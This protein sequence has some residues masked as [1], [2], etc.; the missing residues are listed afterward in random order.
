MIDIMNIKPHE[1]SRDLTGYVIGIYSRPGAGKTTFASQ[2]EK[3]L[4]LATEIG[5]KAIP[6]VMG[7]PINT[8]SDFLIAVSQL[9]RPEAK[10]KY[11][12][13]VIDTLDELVFLATEH[14]LQQ[15][16]VKDLSE[17][18]FGKAYN[19]LEDTLRKP[20]RQLVENY[21]LILL[22][23]DTSK[24]DEEDEKVRYATLNFNKKVKRI[25]MGLLDLLV[26]V[27]MKRGEDDR[28]MHFQSSELWEAKTRFAD[29]EPSAIFSYD[30]FVKVFHNAIDKVATVEEREDFSSRGTQMPSEEEFIAYLEELN[31]LAMYIIEES[32][33]V[34]QVQNLI[35]KHLNG[36]KLGQADLEDYYML[37]NLEEDLKAIK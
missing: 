37:K 19:M 11:K 29:I 17:V 31:A 23:H 15:N 25:V 5:Y 16:G 32:G 34:E 13:I 4:F 27:E 30:N 22:A 10:E 26:Y 21:G 35:G 12:T 6:G 28:I 9:R 20:F 8:W 3:A 7:Q 18:P 33:E 14:V 36:R 2:A 24:Q 1:V